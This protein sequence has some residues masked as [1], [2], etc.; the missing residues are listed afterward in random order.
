[1]FRSGAQDR[2][3]ATQPRLGVI[4]NY[5]AFVFEVLTAAASTAPGWQQWEPAHRDGAGH[6][7]RG[8]LLR[9]QCTAWVRRGARA[10]VTPDSCRANGPGRILPNRSVDSA[11][12]AVALTVGT[13]QCPTC[14]NSCRGGSGAPS[15][16]AE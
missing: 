16:A 14:D 10:S 1:M 8:S 15:R 9:S 4:L 5:A 6:P 3:L 11:T 12:A 13:D 7:G 2:V